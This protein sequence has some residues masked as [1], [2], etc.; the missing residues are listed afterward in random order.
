MGEKGTPKAKVC[1]CINILYETS[2]LFAKKELKVIS[3]K[4]P[5]VDPFHN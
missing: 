3:S 2:I 4:F 5:I 1:A